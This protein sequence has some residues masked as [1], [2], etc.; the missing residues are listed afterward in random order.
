[1]TLHQIF[2]QKAASYGTKSALYFQ[3][4]SYTY[5]ELN[6]LSNKLARVLQDRYAVS[7]GDRVVVLLPKCSYQVVILLALSK[8]G[9]IYVPLTPRDCPHERLVRILKSTDPKCVI[10]SQNQEMMGDY[11]V[12]D[13]TFLIQETFSCSDSVEN[14]S[15]DISEE[16]ILYMIYTS[17]TTSEPKGVP[18]KHL[19]LSYWA[20][21]M[22]SLF[23]SSHQVDV[24]VLS[25][26]L[27]SFDASIWEYL[28]AWIGAS[29]IYMV[30]DV[31]RDNSKQLKTFILKHQITHVTLIPSILRDLVNL[32]LPE[33][34]Q[35]VCS[36]GEACTRDIVAA[37]EVTHQKLF[38]CYGATEETFGLSVQ[39]C[40]LAL[41]DEQFGA[42]IAYPYGDRVRTYIFDQDMREV[43]YGELY[44]ESPYLTPG[45]WRQEEETQQNFIIYEK[46]RLYKTGDYFR[47]D[48]QCNLLR[49][50]G[51]ADS[52]V[53]KIRGAFV[54]LLEIEAYTAELPGVAD[55]CVVPCQRNAHHFL[56]AYIQN[57]DFSSNLVNDIR[58]Y[59][60]VRLSPI[61]IPAQF[62]MTDTPLPLTANGK[63]DRKALQAQYNS[64][65][66]SR[67]LMTEFLPIEH[68]LIEIFQQTLGIAKEAISYSDTFFTLGGDSMSRLALI[69]QIKI[70]FDVELSLQDIYSCDL[71]IP[72]LT[73]L[74]HDC[75]WKKSVSAPISR[76]Q[77]QGEDAKYIFMIHPIT[78][79][80][81]GTYQQLSR[82]LIEV[83]P[84]TSLEIYGLSARGL[85]D[86]LDISANIDLIARDYVRAIRQRQS[87]GTYFLLGW[88]FGGVLAWKVTELLERSEQQ[89]QLIIIDTICPKIIQN[90]SCVS[91]LLLLTQ[92]IDDLKTHLD[93]VIDGCS[94]E[95]SSDTN[96]S[97]IREIFSILI[98]LNQNKST[99]LKVIA[100]LLIANQ[101]YHPKTISAIPHLFLCG[102]TIDKIIDLQDDKRQVANLFTL[103]WSSV[104]TN[105]FTTHLLPNTNHFDFVTNP[106]TMKETAKSLVSVVAKKHEN[107][108]S[109][110]DD[111]KNYIDE[112][113][114]KLG[115]LMSFA[116]LIS[117]TSDSTVLQKEYK[118]SNSSSLGFSSEAF[119]RDK[120][121]DGDQICENGLPYSGR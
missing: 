24:K 49:Y 26:C 7:I 89:V 115:E 21:T 67:C 61:A 17:G 114:K 38:N 18:I 19:G 33:C 53:L 60:S 32:E 56:V 16:S 63:K 51:R 81:I 105:F 103:G 110:L 34:L 101:Q 10:S 57:R 92:L 14:L 11:T 121:M 109:F 1:M 41:F 4:E 37:F 15:L 75:R 13:L 102:R 66:A 12:L 84:N 68:K 94:V 64:I 3:D 95:T 36:T 42:P 82:C 78:G 112:L 98:A 69:N 39:Q 43:E 87:S 118:K 113:Q 45:Y 76:I 62:F 100:A 77:S 120:K 28:M 106:D 58:A 47:K 55:V 30:D 79:E 40:S 31:T 22:L 73:D 117:P 54:N 111:K 9:A 25:F 80:S 29:P 46:K 108:G 107:L 6:A 88:S 119:Y 48:T 23:W 50:L 59:L 20:E 5:A 74:I 96:A 97:Q 27:A 90:M 72:A 44:I 35:V 99:Q 70:A 104:K 65:I 116:M 71:T 8:L 91:H 93:L 83:V 85:L 2:E 52:E 86:P